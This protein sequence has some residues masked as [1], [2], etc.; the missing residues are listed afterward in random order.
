MSG[1]IEPELPQK[2]LTRRRWPRQVAIGLLLPYG[3][4]TAMLAFFQRSLIYLPTCGAVE[5]AEAGF[6]DGQ[7]LAVQRQS[8]D[9]LTL[10]GWLVL[11]DGS[12]SQSVTLPA[13][14][15]RTLI[16]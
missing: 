12:T 3:F 4:L 11:A 10:H 9:G 7:L 13:G 2:R 14:D 15:D 16:L 1:S 6:P 5:T 8:D